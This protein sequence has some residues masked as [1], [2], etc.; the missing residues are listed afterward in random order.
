MCTIG[1]IGQ[2]IR[3]NAGLDEDWTKFLQPPEDNIALQPKA[4]L[5]LTLCIRAQEMYDD[6]HGGNENTTVAPIVLSNLEDFKGTL[7]DNNLA[8]FNG[9]LTPACE[10]AEQGMLDGPGNDSGT[11]DE[12]DG[13]AGIPVGPGPGRAAPAAPHPVTAE[14]GIPPAPHGN[15]NTFRTRPWPPPTSHAGPAPPRPCRCPEF[16]NQFVAEMCSLKRVTVAWTGGATTHVPVPRY[17]GSQSQIHM[18][19]YSQPL[20][21]LLAGRDG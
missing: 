18:S 19:S 6:T 21:R 5:S 16:R 12:V 1:R 8:S 10:H 9:I 13:P 14:P 15:P 20:H 17:Q 3:G 2:G 11:A 7:S 4:G